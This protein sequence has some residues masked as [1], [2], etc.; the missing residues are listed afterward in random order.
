MKPSRI[1]SETAAWFS[2][3]VLVWLLGGF[4]LLFLHEP[5]SKA[6]DLLW[7]KPYQDCY[8]FQEQLEFKARGWTPS[9][10]AE[11]FPM[12]K[13][14]RCLSEDRIFFLEGLKTDRP[15]CLRH[16]GASLP[17]LRRLGWMEPSAP[18]RSPKNYLKALGYPDSIVQRASSDPMRSGDHPRVPCENHI[19]PLSGG[20]GV[21]YLAILG[22][23]FLSP[24]PFRR[25]PPAQA[26]AS[27]MFLAKKD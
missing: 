20:L 27:P 1:V 10:E 6:C 11:A 15:F 16:G 5:H 7:E 24:N 2:P 25:R 18:I 3:F 23:G 22:L 8:A 21:L 12:P 14:S 17:E 19:A 4:L 9:P 26:E 13:P